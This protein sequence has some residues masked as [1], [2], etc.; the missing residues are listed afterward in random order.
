[1]NRAEILK[2]Q[3]DWYK[4]KMNEKK[5]KHVYVVPLLSK[6]SG[7]QLEQL[8][9]GS[10]NP[11]S[12]MF[13]INSSAGLAIN[14]YK[15]FE[16]VIKK[17]NKNFEIEFEWKESIPIL[18]SNA[19]ANIDVRFELNN[20]IYFVESKFLESY[21]D[22]CEKIDDSS[23]YLYFKRY[24]ISATSQ[25]WIDLFSEIKNKITSEK[26]LY[27]NITQLSKH[28][29]A[30]YVDFNENPNK[31]NNKNIVLL[32]VTWEMP[33]LFEQHFNSMKLNNGDLD[34]RKNVLKLESKQCDEILNNFIQN[35]LK[36]GNCKF[37]AKQYNDIDMQ[38][39][40]INAKGYE[41]FKL[42]YFF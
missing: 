19:P 30:I 22:P 27:Y 20:T 14:Y 12:E 36:W 41:K 8:Q 32:S 2:A 23:P 4:N 5:I 42:Q 29:L 21:C 1:M 31:Y 9:N 11:I 39:A 15:L 40:I 25:V 34:S 37:E 6:L 10:G 7:K 16:E 17:Q 3:V 35:K 38:N 26:F 24:K 18:K 33:D 28:L 13:Q